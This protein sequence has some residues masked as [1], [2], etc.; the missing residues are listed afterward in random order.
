MNRLAPLLPLAAV[1]LVA[2]GCGSSSDSSSSKPPAASATTDAGSSSGGAPATTTA[3]PSSDSG[4]AATAVHIRNFAFEPRNVTVKV[5][6]KIEWT[7]DDSTAHNVV[8][9]SGA[10]FAS[11]P[12]DGGQTFSFTPT[13]AGKITY[14]C[15]FHS[16]M[17]GYTITVTG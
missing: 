15:T 17:K 3:A 4:G 13:K 1:A 11:D 14:E 12:I 16:Q 7:N 5:G 2:A 9:D 10:K 8:A 6:Q